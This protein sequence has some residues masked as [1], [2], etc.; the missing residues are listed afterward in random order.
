[1]IKSFRQFNETKHEAWIKHGYEKSSRG[2][3]LDISPDEA[4]EKYAPWFDNLNAETKFY[5]S[6]HS[7]DQV[8]LIDPK[9]SKRYP[10]HTPPFYQLFMDEWQGFPKR[11]ESLIASS[12]RVGIDFYGTSTYQVIPIKENSRIAV[13]P[14]PD[15]WSSF[16]T[17]EKV[18]K[19]NFKPRINYLDSLSYLTES[20]LFDNKPYDRKMDIEEFKKICV[21]KNISGYGLYHDRFKMESVFKSEADEKNF[22][23]TYPRGFHDVFNDLIT[24]DG[25]KVVEYNNDTYIDGRYEVWTDETCLMIKV[26]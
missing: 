17:A 16:N 8:R 7:N 26:E 12:K 20:I 18:K 23:E 6:I 10:R 13:A 11:S 24:P 21:E 22:I 25:F 2:E 19:Y 5:R 14:F 3:K 4:I 1:M 15:I 9:T